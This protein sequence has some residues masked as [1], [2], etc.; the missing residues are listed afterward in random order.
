MTRRAATRS[1]R[2]ALL[3]AAA[4]LMAGC[5]A[6]P[7]VV[8]G[9]PAPLSP[10]PATPT[11]AAPASSSP[12]GPAGTG[13]TATRPPATP[14]ARYETYQLTAHGVTVKVPVPAGWTR[15]ATA[16][17][18]DFGDPS[19]TLLLRIN[20]TP[21]TPGQTVRQSWQAVETGQRL[22]GYQRLD[23]RDVTGYFDGALDWT[24]LF[25]GNG[26]R[27]QVVDRLLVSG[28]AGIAIYFSAPRADFARLLP[29]WNEA[30]D[31][32]AVS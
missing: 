24:F 12:S 21:R 1:V 13:S 23:A 9:N 10:V 19:G 20:V 27:R 18:A 26:G 6:A 28:P 7:Q 30:K 16:L 5:A 22:P 4:A 3:A 25:D 29:I 15:T 32:L 31:G 8:P 14:P 17:G 11:S 2:G